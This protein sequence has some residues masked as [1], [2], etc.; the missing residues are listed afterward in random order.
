MDISQ[1]PFPINLGT[2][3]TTDYTLD[4]DLFVEQWIVPKGTPVK[5]MNGQDFG[6]VILPQNQQDARGFGIPKRI[7]KY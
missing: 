6:F 1:L 3:H 7:F 2:K 4:S 5:L